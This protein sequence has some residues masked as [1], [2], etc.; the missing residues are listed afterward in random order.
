[1]SQSNFEEYKPQD[2]SYTAFQPIPE[3]ISDEN[4]EA[5]LQRQ[6]KRDHRKLLAQWRRDA[7]IKNF[8]TR[9][10]YRFLLMPIGT[11]YDP[12]FQP[13]DQTE[14]PAL[15]NSRANFLLKQRLLQNSFGFYRVEYS[16]LNNFAYSH[17]SLNNGLNFKLHAE[18]ELRG[19][20][21][22]N[23]ESLA[24]LISATESFLRTTIR[25]RTPPYLMN[26]K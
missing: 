22:D 25:E 12:G 2:H 24:E 16:I 7:K 19:S 8:S 1:M 4:V 9:R 26:I 5:Y 13:S 18:I 15:F 21:Q 23:V 10:F 14:Q 17:Y 11:L 6:R 20:F 3:N